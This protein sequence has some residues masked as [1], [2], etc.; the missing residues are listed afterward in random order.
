MAQPKKHTAEFK[1]KIAHEALKDEKTVNQIASEYQVHAA[2]VSQ[3][4]KQALETILEGFKSK[5]E[6]SKTEDG[7]TKD[8]LYS[9]IGQL[10]VEVDWLKKKSAIF[11]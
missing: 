8:E 7:P 10:K 6:Q 11:E 2:Q 1:A 9:Q 3:W 4:K 5:K